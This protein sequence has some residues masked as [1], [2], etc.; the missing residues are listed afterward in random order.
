MKIVKKFNV[1][2]FG[3]NLLFQKLLITLFLVAQNVYNGLFFAVQLLTLILSQTMLWFGLQGVEYS[4]ELRDFN[5]PMFKL[6]CSI[7]ALATQAWIVYEFLNENNSY[8]LNITASLGLLKSKSKPARSDNPNKK[9]KNAG[10]SIN[11]L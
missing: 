9:R 3:D 2:D 5:T 8:S 11:N 10:M 7:S 1:S 6:I 4:G